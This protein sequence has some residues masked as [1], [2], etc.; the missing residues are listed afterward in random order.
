M[1]TRMDKKAESE[2]PPAPAS[3]LRRYLDKAD[4][5]RRRADD[6][7]A[8]EPLKLYPAAR[9]HPV[10]G[11]RVVKDEAEDKAL[12][13]GWTAE[14]PQTALV[15]YPGW[16]YSSTGKDP[17]LVK[18]AADDAKLGPDWYPTVEAAAAAKK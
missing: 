9:H 1:A 8:P 7:L 17:Q 6:A 12:G 18:D 10:H 5:P 4:N 14:A 16:R 2:A 11:S 3:L 13:E 15:T